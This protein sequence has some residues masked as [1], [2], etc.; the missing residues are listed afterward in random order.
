MAEVAKQV[1]ISFESFLQKDPK[2]ALYWN[3]AIGSRIMFG[4]KTKKYFCKECSFWD[5]QKA[6]M[7]NHVELKH[8][9]SFPGYT[10]VLCQLV[11][12][13]WF[14]FKTHVQ[15]NHCSN[16]TEVRNSLKR[17]SDT[18]IKIPQIQAVNINSVKAVIIN[19]VKIVLVL[20]VISDTRAADI[21][22]SRRFETVWKP[23]DAATALFG[24][25]CD[26]QCCQ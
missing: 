22:E 21:K 23:E 12:Q 19:N 3:K 25:C 15:K 16:P 18:K 1:K 6:N 8:L 26:K 13:T 14:I 4:S 11:F 7:V 9:H 2:D 24:L 17:L 5:S 20:M 10:C